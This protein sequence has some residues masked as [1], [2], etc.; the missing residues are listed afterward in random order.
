MEQVLTWCHPN[1]QAI[2]KFFKADSTGLF[3]S[4]LM[5]HEVIWFQS[6]LNLENI[7]LLV[8]LQL[9][10]SAFSLLIWHIIMVSLVHL[11]LSHLIPT[12]FILFL[13]WL[14]LH[15]VLV[16]Y[17]TSDPAEGTCN[18]DND[19]DYHHLTSVRFILFS[20][21]FVLKQGLLL[22]LLAASFCWFF[23]V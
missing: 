18:H 6:V 17:P 23:H 21:W 20:L 13:L 15:V 22:F 1:F 7:L 5:L 16:K 11:F 8:L 12:C 2:F 4:G 19:H 10:E 9:L 14:L 3:R